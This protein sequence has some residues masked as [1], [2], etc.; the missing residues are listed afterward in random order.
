MR[1][2]LGVVTIERPHA[3]ARLIRSA[4]RRWPDMPIYVAD[5]SANID[6]LRG[7]YAEYRV[8][9]VRMPFDAGLGASRNALVGAIGEEFFL[10]CDDDFVLGGQTCIDQA[11]AVLDGATDI[12]V[13]G[14]RLHD[15]D[16]RGERVRNWEMFFHHDPR[17]RTF[18]AIPIHYYAPLARWVAGVEIFMCDAVLISACFAGRSSRSVFVGTA[19]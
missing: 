11:V 6:A 1:V 13:V 4:R 19:T 8:N 7:F 16:E 17:H 9:V 2:A 18:T 12:A 3:V 15:L 5:Q 10:L 14:G